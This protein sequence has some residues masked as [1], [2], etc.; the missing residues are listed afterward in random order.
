M[1]E[2]L[3][4][5]KHF[6]GPLPER[7]ILARYFRVLDRA[8]H[9]ARAGCRG[10]WPEVVQQ[11]T[12]AIDRA[13]PDPLAA[14][15]R[16]IR[17]HL[18]RTERAIVE[19]RFLCDE[20]IDLKGRPFSLT[21]TQEPGAARM[22]A[23]GCS[24]AWALLDAVHNLPELLTNWHDSFWCTPRVQFDALRDYERKYES[25]LARFTGFLTPVDQVDPQTWPA[26][27]PGV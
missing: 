19:S 27:Q 17:L 20:P 4:Q 25:G 10:S 2:W 14:D 22:L 9:A 12:L 18:Y 26:R 3:L 11:L 5:Q 8:L 1:S 7:W 21:Q 24:Q 13:A 15:E 16:S 23:P 6:Q